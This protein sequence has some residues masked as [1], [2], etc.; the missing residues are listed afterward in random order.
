MTFKYAHADLEIRKAVGKT[1]GVTQAELSELIAAEFGYSRVAMSSRISYMLNKC[2]LFAS[3]GAYNRRAT[4]RLWLHPVPGTPEELTRIK[5]PTRHKGERGENKKAAQ[6]QEEMELEQAAQVPPAYEP[7]YARSIP[8]GVAITPEPPPPSALSWHP[9]LPALV[10]ECKG[11]RYEIAVEHLQY[12]RK[13][14]DAAI[15][16]LRGM[17]FGE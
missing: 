11:T 7:V 6:V 17:F 14:L 4:Y 10:I 16:R 13:G 3:R 15:D 1:P 5:H 8:T 2:M 9:T 12:V